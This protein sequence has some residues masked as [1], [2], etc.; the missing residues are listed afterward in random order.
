VS[1]A[2]AVTYEHKFVTSP[3]HRYAVLQHSLKNGNLSVA[4]AVARELQHV[5]LAMK[6][7]RRYLDEKEPTLKN[8]AKVVR[9]L[10]KPS[11]EGA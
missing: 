11:S 9:E 6:W 4:D 7:L 1:E 8:F 5:W 3:G 10:E 2:E